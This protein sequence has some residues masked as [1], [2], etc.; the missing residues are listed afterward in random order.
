MRLPGRDRPVRR[1]HPGP[2]PA[3]PEHQQPHTIELYRH[4]VRTGAWWD[5]VDE[6]ATHLVHGLLERHPNAITPQLHDWARDD[7]LWVRRSAIVCQ[8]GDVTISTGTCWSMRSMPTSTLDPH[9][10]GEVAY[11]REFLR[12]RRSAGRCA[13][14]R[15]TDPEPGGCAR[16]SPTA[17]SAG[18][19]RREAPQAHG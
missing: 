16:S 10:T 11:G 17:V 9:H 8:V 3:L 12:R 2:T 5:H 6:V 4:F 13:T 14:T 19:S 7:D 18:L 1:D 15:A